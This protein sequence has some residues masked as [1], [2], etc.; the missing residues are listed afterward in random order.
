MEDKLKTTKTLRKEKR[1]KE[2]TSCRSK[3]DDRKKI[4]KEDERKNKKLRTNYCITRVWVTC[5]IRLVTCWV[6]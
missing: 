1:D 2:S 6:Q 5:C 3:E 4:K